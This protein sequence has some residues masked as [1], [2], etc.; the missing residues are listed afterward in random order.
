MASLARTGYLELFARQQ[1]HRISVTLDET[2]L[3]LNIEE[4]GIGNAPPNMYACLIFFNISVSNSVF[5]FLFI[6]SIP[7]FT[8]CNLK[9][10]PHW[11]GFITVN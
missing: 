1:W 10:F 3:V 7:V 8:P 9:K 11:N 4:G 2:A 5:Q 6:D